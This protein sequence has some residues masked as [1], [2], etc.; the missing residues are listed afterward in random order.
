MTDTKHA[1]LMIEYDDGSRSAFEF[2]H[3]DTATLNH[4]GLPGKATMF[5]SGIC[6]AI[7]QFPISPVEQSFIEAIATLEPPR[8]EPHR[9]SGQ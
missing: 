4:A 5:L 1:V 3:L 2:I 7:R 6:N 8:E 9:E